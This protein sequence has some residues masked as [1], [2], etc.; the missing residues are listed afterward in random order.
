MVEDQ[1][2]WEIAFGKLDDDTVKLLKSSANAVPGGVTALI[3]LIE[4]TKQKKMANEAKN[5]GWNI[6]I[7]GPSRRDPKILNLRNMVYKIME[8]AL[9]FKDIVTKML[10]LDPT[11]YGMSI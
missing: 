7:P 1:D 4:D 9:E 11:Q 2:L 3:A 5:T 10:V 6:T 8:A